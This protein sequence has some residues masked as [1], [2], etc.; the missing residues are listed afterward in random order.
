MKNIVQEL[1]WLSK[2]NLHIKNPHDLNEKLKNMAQG[3][4]NRLQVV[5]DFDFTITKQHQDGEPNLSSFAMFA[6]VPT[7]ANNEQYIKNEQYLR[8][9]YFP[10]EV[11]PSIP[12][13]EKVKHMEDWWSLAEK[14][15][16]GLTIP[17]LEI[18]SISME[19]KPALR[20]GTNELFED[21]QKEKVPIIVFS[22]GIGDMVT[23]VLKHCDVYFCNV[24]VISNFLK[25]NDEGVIEGFRDKLIHVFNKNE[26]AIKNTGF[27]DVVAERENA[28][29]LGDSLG[30]AN[31]TE[32][33]ENLKNVLKIG[34][35]YNH[36]DQ[37]LPSYM[38][39]F[40]IVLVDDQTMNVP[41]EILN[42]IKNSK[43]EN[44]IK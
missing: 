33:M 3:G 5:S 7:L 1:G 19:V 13:E 15:L 43:E 42:Y 39:N 29:V 10:I 4:V 28:L 36:V 17:Q 14:A 40:D 31:M 6:K 30:D 27:F 41:K 25:Y 21:L 20:D 24:K 18:D 38:E 9:K 23:A 44:I 35:L 2:P 11:D 8:N 37:A 26:C 22:A 12:H 34:F 32:G 16:C